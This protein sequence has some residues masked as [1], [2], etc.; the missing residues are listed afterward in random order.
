MAVVFGVGGKPGTVW[1]YTKQTA[2]A[3]AKLLPNTSEE[4]KARDAG[5]IA[6]DFDNLLKG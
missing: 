4:A 1:F 6:E 5:E 3:L 2:I